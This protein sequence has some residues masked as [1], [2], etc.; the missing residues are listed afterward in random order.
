MKQITWEFGYIAN[1]IRRV[2]NAN[3]MCVDVEMGVHKIRAPLMDYK[4]PLTI[5]TKLSENCRAEN[6]EQLEEK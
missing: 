1:R 5:V 4:L 3:V 2:V 6:G